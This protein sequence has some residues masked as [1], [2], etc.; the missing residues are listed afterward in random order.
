MF[1]NLILQ[2]LHFSEPLP[3]LLKSSSCLMR[4]CARAR[5]KLWTH[6]HAQTRAAALVRRN[7]DGGMDRGAHGRGYGGW[8][9][10]QVVFRAGLG[11]LAPM[12]HAGLVASLEGRTHAPDVFRFAKRAGLSDFGLALQLCSDP[13]SFVRA[14]LDCAG[15]DP[16][17]H[18]ATPIR[19]K[20]GGAETGHCLGHGSF[21]APINL[22]FRSQTRLPLPLPPEET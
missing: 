18:S 9:Q 15:R 19:D 14:L 2:K 5:E 11:G 4:A 7:R 6:G 1:P 22:A 3:R 8:L 17:A 13:S 16:F 20:V 10:G 21:K 12:R